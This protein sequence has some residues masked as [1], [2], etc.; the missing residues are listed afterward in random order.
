[1][2]GIDTGYQGFE[3]IPLTLLASVRVGCPNQ[4]N[5][6]YLLHCLR[7][8]RLALHTCHHFL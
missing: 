1:V 6:L 5:W 7:F 4:L 3:S 2:P 8:R